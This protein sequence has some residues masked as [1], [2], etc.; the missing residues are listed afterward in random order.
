MLL[1]FFRQKQMKNQRDNAG[2]SISRLHKQ[3]NRIQKSSQRGI[4]SRIR[5]EITEPVGHE[6]SADTDGQGTR[7]NEAVSS[8][9]FADSENSDT[10][11]GNGSEKECG[12]STEDSR[13]DSNEDGREF[14]E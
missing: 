12:H 7:H 1:R 6:D 10:G 14:G 4:G 2:K 8:G 13:G 9:E 3:R 5:K 11:D